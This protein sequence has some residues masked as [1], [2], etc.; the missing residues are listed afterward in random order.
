V[1]KLVYINLVKFVKN[2]FVCVLKCLA[3]FLFLFP[4]N[5]FGHLYSNSCFR[6]K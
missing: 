5:I 6:N 4:E 2:S 3:A 1:N